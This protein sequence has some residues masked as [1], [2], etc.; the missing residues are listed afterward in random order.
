MHQGVTPGSHPIDFNTFTTTLFQDTVLPKYIEFLKVVHRKHTYRAFYCS[1]LIEHLFYYRLA[2]KTRE[3][4]YGLPPNTD[5][6][7]DTT[8][9]EKTIDDIGTSSA[10]D[11]NEPSIDAHESNDTNT[12]S[13]S[14]TAHSENLSRP[15][16]S[17]TPDLSVATHSNQNSCD[18]TP[19][20]EDIDN[21][22]CDNDE[23][24]SGND[25][26]RD[27]GKC[28]HSAIFYAC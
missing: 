20:I 23:Q 1:K 17:N 9:G 3:E 15:T 6:S 2:R 21:G 8:P 16:P 24:E 28:A 4:K 27:I 26:S 5:I 12:D 11:G 18:D 19:F 13:N 14:E 7:T 22:R 25:T 10:N